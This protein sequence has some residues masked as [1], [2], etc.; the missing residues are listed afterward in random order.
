MHAEEFQSAVWRCTAH[1]TLL[2]EYVY[3]FSLLLALLLRCRKQSHLHS[4][5]HGMMRMM[6]TTAIATTADSGQIERTEAVE[7]AEDSMGDS[8]AMED[9]TR[10][11]SEAIEES[12]FKAM[13]D[14]TENHIKEDL[15]EDMEEQGIEE[16]TEGMVISIMQINAQR[17]DVTSAE[18]QAVGQ[19]SIQLRSGRTRTTS[20]DNRQQHTRRKGQS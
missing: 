7:E 12:H 17:R 16:H 4:T 3:R 10:S 6:T 9:N 2:R 18:R 1:L 5:Q 15:P 8:E 20:S 11:H 13:E 14:N 19:P